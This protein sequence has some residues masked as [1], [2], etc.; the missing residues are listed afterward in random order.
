MFKAPIDR[1]TIDP[2]RAAKSPKL[3]VLLGIFRTYLVF[4]ELLLIYEIL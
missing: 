1:D 2:K 3:C 4:S